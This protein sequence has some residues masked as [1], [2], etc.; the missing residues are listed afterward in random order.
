MPSNITVED[1]TLK[2]GFI[3]TPILIVE[4]L[5]LG[6]AAMYGVLLW[7]FYR[8]LNYPGHAEVARDFSISERAVERYLSELKSAELVTCHRP[9]L[10]KPNT[11]TLHPIETIS[12]DS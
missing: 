12:R 5:G 9:G 3:M 6:P 7:Y 2:R 8:D 10:G 11:Y 4:Q 1:K